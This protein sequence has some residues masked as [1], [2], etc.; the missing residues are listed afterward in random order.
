M[1]VSR[2]LVAGVPS[3]VQNRSMRRRT[4]KRSGVRRLSQQ[5]LQRRERGRIDARLRRHPHRHARCPIQHPP[6]Q[7][8]PAIQ[9]SLVETATKNDVSRL[10]DHLMD[11]NHTPK[12]RMPGI[13]HLACLGPVGVPSSRCTTTSG[14]TSATVTRAAGRG[15]PSSASSAS[16]PQDKKVKTTNELKALPVTSWGAHDCRLFLWTTDAHLPQALALG[17]AWGF[18][19]STVAF[20][21]AKQN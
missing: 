18:R 4:T 14:R 3:C 1:G 11:A 6:R 16:H 21:W 12:P 15:T 17:E 19:Y 7:L 2:L 5:R 9:A 8:E 13:L 20:V 10:F